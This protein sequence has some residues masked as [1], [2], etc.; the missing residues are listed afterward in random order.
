MSRSAG[1]IQAHSF[2]Q[3]GPPEER[4]SD[5]PMADSQEGSDDIMPYN[6]IN[7]DHR[8][9]AVEEHPGL[10]SSRDFKNLESASKYI[11]QVRNSRSK[12]LILDEL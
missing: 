8:L 3:D 9:V 11:D 7:I 4:K 5:M 6:R 2:G 1:F 12:V 10:E